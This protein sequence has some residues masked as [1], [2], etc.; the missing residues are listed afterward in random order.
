MVF[1]CLGD[2]LKKGSKEIGT[3]TLGVS[4]GGN[5]KTERGKK[6][7]KM[8]DPEKAQPVEGDVDVDEGVEEEEEHTGPA[9]NQGPLPVG[10]ELDVPDVPP[11]V[12]RR[13]KALKKIQVEITQ[14]ESQ[15]FREMHDLEVKYAPMYTEHFE[16]VS[17]WQ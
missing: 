4:G 14:I 2:F 10:L 1:C 15:F 3:K 8:S 5:V 9:S 7:V 6:K 12:Q 17:K 11:E 13:I 16:K